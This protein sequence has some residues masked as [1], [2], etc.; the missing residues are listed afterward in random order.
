[1]SRKKK[2]SKVKIYAGKTEEEWREW[3]EEFGK[4]MEKLGDS[5]G[6]DMKKRGRIVEKR[7]R[8]RWFD[9]FG[10]IG[11]LIGSMMGIFFLAIAIWFLN[12][13][14]S[15]LSNAFISLLSDFLFTNIPIFFLASIFFGFV[16]YFSRIYWKDFW[17]AWPIAGS[18][19]VIFVIWILASILFLTGA[20]T[21]ND[22]IETLSIIVIRNLFGLF[23]VFAVIGYFIVL[24]QRTK[25]F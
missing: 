15:Y 9:T 24:A 6:K 14:N 3:G 7:Y 18:L 12:F 5:F 23:I 1:M 17:I 11:P 25:N 22:A 20:Y 13:I 8:K 10:F 4:Q 16:K 21:M 2:T 19:R